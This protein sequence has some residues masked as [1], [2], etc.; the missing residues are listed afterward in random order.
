M[1]LKLNN[2]R[3]VIVKENCIDCF[4][5]YFH[6]WGLYNAGEYALTCAIVEDLKG[7]ISCIPAYDIRFIEN[8]PEEKLRMP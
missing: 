8:F 5:G 1:N 4:Y 2:M 6:Q 3:K 7:I